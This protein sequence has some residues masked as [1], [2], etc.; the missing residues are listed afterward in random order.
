MAVINKQF[1][2]TDLISTTLVGKYVSVDR[3]T[4]GLPTRSGV[5][6]R[7]Y[8]SGSGPEFT[9]MLVGTS[10]VDEYRIHPTYHTIN[11]LEQ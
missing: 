2:L 8:H 10:G 6:R 5:V 9:I 1:K 4:H 3:S 11:I 7:V